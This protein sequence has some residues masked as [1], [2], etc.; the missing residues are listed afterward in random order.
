MIELYLLTQTVLLLIAVFILYLIH[1]KIWYTCKYIYDID[2]ILCNIR[3]YTISI[4]DNIQQS[5]KLIKLLY[6]I[7]DKLNNGN[8]KSTKCDKG[9]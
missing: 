5:K 8:K 6:V 4:S 2:N 3:R 9:R 1:K 7:N